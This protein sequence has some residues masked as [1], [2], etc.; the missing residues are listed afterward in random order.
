MVAW[1]LIPPG[2]DLTGFLA[3]LVVEQAA[4]YYDPVG[5]QM[6]LANW[7]PADAQRE[8]LVHELVHALQD[9]QVDLDRF[10]GLPAGQGDAVLARQS[11]V[12]GEAVALTMDRTLRRTGQDLASLPDVTAF[13]QAI[14]RSATGPTLGQAP[15][16]L[17]ALLTFPYA[18]GL[19]FVHQFRRRHPWAEVSRL[20]A[21]PPR[22]TTHILHPERYFDRREDPIALA[23]PDF[24]PLLGAGARRVLEDEAGEFGLGRVL[25]EF[26]GDG[27]GAPGWRGDRY[28]VWDLG[29][30]TALV[31]LSTWESEGIATTFATAYGRLLLR[32]HALGPPAIAAAELQVW[33]APEGALAVERRGREV[34]IAERV[35][36]AALDGLRQAV[37]AS[38]GAYRTPARLRSTIPT[39][40]TVAPSAISR[41][42]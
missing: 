19:G 23:L 37:W 17:R 31:S 4:A 36:P 32:K 11:L 21:D 13:R 33:R 12:E 41:T 3:D 5:K 8:A 26:L 28:A 30:A 18:E 24:T 14:G 2:F 9:R 15:R 1:G 7:L 22:S 29:G 6:V 34:L 20:Y 16:Y 39:S 27:A 10:L 25:A 35:P 40:M 38:R 42:R